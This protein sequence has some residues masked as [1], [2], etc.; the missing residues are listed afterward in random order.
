MRQP[1]EVLQLHRRAILDML[2]EI[3]GEHNDDVIQKWLQGW[4]FRISRREVR[5]Q[6]QWLAE[7]DLVR[8]EEFGEF[9]EVG[10]N[11]IMVVR[12]TP[13]GRDV[14]DGLMSVDGVSRHKTRL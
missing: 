11:V 8:A 10:G 14:S 2:N 1:E 7:R 9:G 4:K 6:L 13:D 5:V 12:I 3:G